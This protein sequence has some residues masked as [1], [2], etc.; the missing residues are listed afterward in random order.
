MPYT[1]SLSLPTCHRLLTAMHI[2]SA[3]P[4]LLFLVPV[5][6]MASEALIY[7]LVYECE[8]EEINRVMVETCT[9]RFPGLSK[10]ADVALAAWRDRNLAKANAARQACAGDL[11]T[12]ERY[13][14]PNDVEAVRKSAADIKAQMFSGFETDIRKRGLAACRDALKQL[15]T[16]GGPLE[17]R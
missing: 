8:A 6:S 10:E 2:R 16:V 13:A 3:L 15:Q 11:S 9:T 1:A 7:G 5:A 4:A 14:S 12:A 17:M